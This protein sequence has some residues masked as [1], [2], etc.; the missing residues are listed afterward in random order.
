ML[1]YCTLGSGPPPTVARA[2]PHPRPLPRPYVQCPLRAATWQAGS[3]GLC[4][5]GCPAPGARVDHILRFLRS[6]LSSG[7][8]PRPPVSL[9]HPSGMAFGESTESA[10]LGSSVSGQRCDQGQ[11]INSQ[12]QFCLE[13]RGDM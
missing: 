3:P 13:I 5:L 7:L 4:V 6:F 11:M 12:S 10:G 1:Q 8:C 2:S 9:P